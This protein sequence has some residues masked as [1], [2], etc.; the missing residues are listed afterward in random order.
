MPRYRVDAGGIYAS[1]GE[2]IK[3]GTVLDLKEA[4]AQ[5]S[6]RLTALD[7][8][9]TENHEFVASASYEAVEGKGGWYVINDADGN[10]V[11]KGVRQDVAEEFNAKDADGKI[12]FVQEHVKA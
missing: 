2:E 12:A 9:V 8:P 7:A 6:G 3:I 10:Q 5:W 1:S 11:G 4:P